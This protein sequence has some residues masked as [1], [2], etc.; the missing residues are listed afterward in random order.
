MVDRK[1]RTH[2]G[3]GEIQ[4]SVEYRKI[5]VRRYDVDLICLEHR[6]IG[7]SYDADLALSGQQLG[8][9]ARIVRR[10]VLDH[11]HGRI[12]AGNVTKEFLEGLQ[13]SR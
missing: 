12:D 1:V 8:Q 2:N 11:H 5:G 13:S 9:G 7:R 10:Q 4:N 3:R 6:A